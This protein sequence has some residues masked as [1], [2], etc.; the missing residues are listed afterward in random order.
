MNKQA[1]EVSLEQTDKEFF[2]ETALTFVTSFIPGISALMSSHYADKHRERIQK[3]LKQISDK[4]IEIDNKVESENQHKFIIEVVKEVL[5]TTDNEKL[6]FLREAVD[7]AIKGN[8]IKETKKLDVICRLIRDITPDEAKF[9]VKLVKLGKNKVR[10]AY[11]KKEED[12]IF[13]VVV[14]SND[15]DLHSRLTGLGLF[16]VPNTFDACSI[17]TS[18]GHE[19][20]R[21]L[22]EKEPDSDGR[23]GHP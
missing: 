10:V 13:Y 7:S 22:I 15:G 3:I 19:L 14:G 5:N 2:S 21:L 16:S 18:T 4:L 9:L 11:E 20:A 8:T 23:Q 12:K 17:L 6:E 1:I